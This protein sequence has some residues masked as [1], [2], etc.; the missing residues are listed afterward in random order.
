MPASIVILIAMTV[1]V[2]I[3]AVY[4]NV[5]ARNEDDLVHIADP[6][7]QVI[8]NQRKMATTLKQFDDLGIGLTVATAV[9]GCGLLAVNMYS[10]LMR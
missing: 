2:A 10:T 4:R 7:S 9:Y 8:I 6:A 5:V 1:V 3:L